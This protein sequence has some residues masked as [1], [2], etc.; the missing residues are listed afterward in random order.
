MTI[1][2]LTLILMYLVDTF[3]VG[4][5]FHAVKERFQWNISYRNRMIILFAI[6]AFLDNYF[7]PMIITL[8]MTYTIRN[9][10]V[11]AFLDLKP[12]EPFADLFNFGFF[13]LATWLVQSFFANYVGEKVLIN[14]SK[15]VA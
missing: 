15:Q 4:I 12:N 6:F 2:I 3:L 1:F 13:E 8:D 11:V 7:L 10:A 5:A 14:R 9:P